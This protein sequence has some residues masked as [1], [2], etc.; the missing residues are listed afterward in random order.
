MAARIDHSVGLI[1]TDGGH[2]GAS[3]GGGGAARQD[4]EMK[5]QGMLLAIIS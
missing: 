3:Y 5:L 4:T 2:L 1:K